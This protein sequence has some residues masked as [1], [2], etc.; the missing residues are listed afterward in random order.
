MGSITE[1]GFAAN[2]IG[3]VAIY[4]ESGKDVTGNYEITLEYGI[5]TVLGLGPDG[6]GGLGGLLGM[7]NQSG[8]QT[9]MT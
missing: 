7:I 2:T 1:V 9:V 3:S 6:L 5:L 8:M 4:N